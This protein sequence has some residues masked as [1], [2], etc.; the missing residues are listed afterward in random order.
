MK[1]FKL[2]LFKKIIA[3]LYSWTFPDKPETMD[4]L[5]ERF[6][7]YGISI[8]ENCM[9]YSKLGNGRDAFL[10]QIGNNVTISGNVQFLM[11]DNAVC[12]PSEG[13]YTDILGKV[14]IGDN[15]FIGYGSIILP[16][17]KIANNCIVGGRGCCNA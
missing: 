4:D 12:K 15:C 5:I 7:S 9:I 10:L 8:G 17:C 3:K 1:I 16:G 13:K 6:R 2:N 11:H 14:I